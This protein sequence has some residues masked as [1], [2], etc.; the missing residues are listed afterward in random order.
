MNFDIRNI[1]RLHKE[2]RQQRGANHRRLKRG[3]N[4]ASRVHQH[5]HLHLP[6]SAPVD[7]LFHPRQLVPSTSHSR[8]KMAVLDAVPGIRV[9]IESGGETLDEYPDEADFNYKT[10]RTLDGHKSKSYI[11][12][13]SD[14]EFQ[15]KFELMPGFEPGPA[16]L[17]YFWAV[18]D[19][20]EI[21]G[22]SEDPY[23]PF[24]FVLKDSI[25]RI[26]DSE[27]VRRTLKFQSIKKGQSH[28]FG[29]PV[30][31]PWFCRP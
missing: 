23:T 18:V 10:F 24:G 12:C 20:Q 14:T 26:N 4:D 16:T 31:I 5:L 6:T 1:Y 29:V 11:E 19:G 21:G 25:H 2:A 7:L 13:T 15:I 30:E 22:F 27:C 3:C 17:V 9:T 28:F 8:F